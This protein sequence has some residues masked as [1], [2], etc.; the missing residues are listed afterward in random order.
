M[1]ISGHFGDDF[2]MLH[3]PTR[4]VEAPSDFCLQCAIRNFRLT[5]LHTGGLYGLYQYQ[6]LQTEINIGVK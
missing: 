5:D 1:S 3:S 6:L 4:S 2:Y